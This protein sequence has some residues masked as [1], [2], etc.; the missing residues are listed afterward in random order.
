MDCF[1]V[2]SSLLLPKM[3]Q[4]VK[5]TC[6]LQGL[7][8]RLQGSSTEAGKGTAEMAAIAHFICRV[9]FW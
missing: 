7:A 9:L 5:G 2:A 6:E 4:G 3:S 1:S 8:S